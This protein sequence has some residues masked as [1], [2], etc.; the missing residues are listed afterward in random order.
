MVPEPR[1]GPPLITIRVGSPPVWESTTWICLVT[2][3]RT[4][5]FLPSRF[6][7]RQLRPAANAAADEVQNPFSLF[8]FQ[9][10]SRRSNRFRTHAAFGHR[11]LDE[12]DQFDVRVE[13]QQ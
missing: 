3:F 5:L 4:T 8:T 10:H 13:M 9:N 11:Q 12:L 7:L 2:V 1:S 6:V